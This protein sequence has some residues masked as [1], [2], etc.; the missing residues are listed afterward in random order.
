MELESHAEDLASDLGVDKTEVKT[1]LENL[2]AYS[3]PLDEAKQSLRRK[4][5]DGGGD[6][7]TPSATA[8]A[9]I[10]PNTG[11]ATVT[12]TVLTVGTRR[13]QYRGEDHVI[14]EGAVADETGRISYTAWEDFDVEPGETVTIANASVRE[15]EGQPE[16]NVGEHTSV[17]VA[18][19][20]QSVPYEV[21]GDAT[22]ADLEPGD[23]GRTV[24][25]L[26]LDVESRTIDGR[27]GE[28]EILSGVLGDE[29]ARLPFTDWDPHD[30]I[31]AERSLRLEN[32][33]VREFRGVPSVNVSEFSAV[34]PTDEAVEPGGPTELSVGEAVDRGGVYDVALTGNVIEIRD[35]SGLIQRCPECGRVVKKGQCRQHGDVEG[36]DDLRV[37]AILDDGTGTA[38]VVLDDELT[39]A[40][41]GGDIDDAREQARDAM[42]QS[43]VA[44]TIAERLVGHEYR[45]RGHLSVDEYGSTLE[46]TDFDRSD[47]DPA[48]RART[49]LSEVEA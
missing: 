44:D 41:Y 34:E 40:V 6:G 42:D 47:D 5:G 46:A 26:V 19:E 33:Y 13:I 10:T 49:L 2:L 9:E 25:V 29:T 37:K 11:S 16:L 8:V 24:E 4:Y 18:D 28:T 15:W 17:T 38:T 21:G 1:D 31:A 12:V 23:R 36:E 35:G 3:V 45:V 32:V 14:R 30:A 48:G 27:D 39:E 22:L 7:G 43:V 20:A